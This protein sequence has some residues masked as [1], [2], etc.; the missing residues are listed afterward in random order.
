MIASSEERKQI[1]ETDLEFKKLLTSKE[2]LYNNE[3]AKDQRDYQTAPDIENKVF[4]DFLRINHVQR[5]H[6]VIKEYELDSKISWRGI[7]YCKW[8]R[9]VCDSHGLP[10]KDLYN[11]K[12]G[13]MTL[14][15]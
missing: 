11:T 10:V 4:T 1:I 6:K 5:A 9:A 3:A 7:P 2:E 14:L 12:F 8:V 13:Q 15:C